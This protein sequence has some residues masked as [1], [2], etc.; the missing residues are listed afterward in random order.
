MPLGKVKISLANGALGSVSA[1][2]DGIGGLIISIDAP[3]S[4]LALATPKVIFNLKEAEALGITSALFPKQHRQIKE[5]YDGILYITGSENAELW[6]MLVADTTS[7]TQMADNT[8]ASGAKKLLD[9]ASGRIKLL[10]FSRVPASGYTPTT[11][12]GIDLDVENAVTNAQVLAA[13]AATAQKPVRCLIEGRNMLFASVGSWPDLRALS[14]NRV[15]IVAWST[16]NDKSASLGFVLGVACGLPVQR[17]IGRVKNGPLPLTVQ[18][19]IGDSTVEAALAS[20]DSVHDKG[21]IILR[22][23]VGKAGYFMNDDPMAAP[24]SDDYAQ[25]GRGRVIDKAHR[26]TY[27]TLVD[28]LNDDV[29]TIDGGKLHPA[30][31]ATINAK[32]ERAVKTQMAG[33]LS[34]NEDGT[35]AFRSFI[36]PDQN[37]LST[38]L[39]KMKMRARPKGYL[40]DIEVDLGFALTL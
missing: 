14:A 6:I 27:L 5:F 37:V 39:L 7:L 15:G 23:L 9:G 28:E 26:I 38:S 11:T 2:G 8:N 33:E 10:G 24:T 34:A 20:L 32:V 12:N 25:L 29:D 4:G 3:P 31:I 36:D 16:A 17:N 13:A 21:Y 22:T 19:Y 40:K 1:T 18:P 30:V 35:V